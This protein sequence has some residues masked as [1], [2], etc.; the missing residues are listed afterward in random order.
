MELRDLLPPP[1]LIMVSCAIYAIAPYA[2]ERPIVVDRQA[3]VTDKADGAS[4]VDAK[5]PLVQDSQSTAISDSQRN[6]MRVRPL[7]SQT[8]RP[9]AVRVPDKK[10]QEEP[11][12]DT[13]TAPPPRPA[14]PDIRFLGV[15]KSGKAYKG[16]IRDQA[17]QRETWIEVGDNVTD[18]RIVAI[19]EHSL[20]LSQNE[21]E[22]VVEL[23][24]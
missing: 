5:S 13:I 18:W 20:V 12:T 7:F 17:T 1:I 2:I 11:E 6:E 3:T 24:P 21:Y 16:L 23:K 15:I 22:F 4:E 8:R 19:S 9:P 14:D 10:L